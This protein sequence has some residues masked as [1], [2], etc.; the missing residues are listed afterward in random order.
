VNQVPFRLSSSAD[1][2]DPEHRLMVLGGVQR[3]AGE[4][5]L[6][7]SDVVFTLVS[8]TAGD[9]RSLRVPYDAI[10]SAV[11]RAGIL[12]WRLRL[13]A[14]QGREFAAVAPRSPN[15]VTLL[16][17]RRHR[18]EARDF[19]AALQVRIT[20]SRLPGRQPPA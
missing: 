16:I 9:P 4:V 18:A 15:E 8:P 6:D 14:R 19:T 3:V 17:D 7:D 13:T 10:A 11:L 2:A 5:S 20:E 12:T 1:D